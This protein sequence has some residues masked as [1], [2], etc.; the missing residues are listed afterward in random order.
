MQAVS[1]D[2]EPTEA[3]MKYFVCLIATIGLLPAILGRVVDRQSSHGSERN[4]ISTDE[5]FA[6]GG[7]GIVAED[8]YIDL[9]SPNNELSNQTGDWVGR[10]RT[11]REVIVF[12]GNRVFPTTAVP[13]DFTL[14]DAIIVSFEGEVVRFFDAK[15]FRG[16]YYRRIGTH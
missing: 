9:K 11:E 5:Y 7:L 8:L 4:M 1:E 10:K 6:K 15:T 2:D 14:S 12:F 16:G 3:H 13:K